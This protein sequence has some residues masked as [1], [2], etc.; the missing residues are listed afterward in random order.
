[1]DNIKL[2]K[3]L[4]ILKS[5]ICDLPKN[6]GNRNEVRYK[7]FIESSE[8]QSLVRLLFTHKVLDRNSTRVLVCARFPGDS[9]KEKVL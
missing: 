6:L 4:D 5:S 3:M 2:R 7:L 9:E 8:D 1:M